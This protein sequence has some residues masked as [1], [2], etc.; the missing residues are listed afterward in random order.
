MDAVEF[1]R[2]LRKLKS[3]SSAFTKVYKFY[4]PK[5]VLHITSKYRNK[6]LGEEVAQEFFVKLLKMSVE[7]HIKSP[8]AWVY[9]VV[10]NIA[11]NILA[12]ENYFNKVPIEEELVPAQDEF[13]DDFYGEYSEKLQRLDEETRDI[14]VLRIWEQWSFKEIAELKGLKCGTIRQKYARGINKL[15]NM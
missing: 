5:I 1:N 2:L 6:G 15:K 14:L 13:E 9:T 11:K 7:E 4:F 3:K 10:D 8:N 12:R